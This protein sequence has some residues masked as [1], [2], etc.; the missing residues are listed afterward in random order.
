MS[1]GSF[2]AVLDDTD[3]V[4]Y[5][6]VKVIDIGEQTTHLHYHVTKGNRL[7]TAKWLPLYVQ[8]HT[9]LIVTEQPDTITREHTP[10]TG[11]I[12]TMPLEDSLI[13]LPNIGMTDK[14]RVNARTRQILTR[15]T[16]YRHHRINHTWR[17]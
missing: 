9:H 15:K 17:P 8:P 13:L 7:W 1:V 2:V 5:H 16:R 4:H 14:M 10:F 6:I 3:D 11:D 12:N